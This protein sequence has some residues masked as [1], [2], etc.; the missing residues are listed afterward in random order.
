M[1]DLGGLEADESVP[2]LVRRPVPRLSYRDVVV[3][4]PPCGDPAAYTSLLDL[5]LAAGATIVAAPLARLSEAV[6]A[7]KGTA[8]IVPLGTDV[9][10]LPPGRVLGVG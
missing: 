8:V 1:F 4:V 5:A 9:P 7:Y 3:A 6:D 2:Q 10:G